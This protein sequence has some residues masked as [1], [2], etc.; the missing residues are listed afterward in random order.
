MKK[1]KYKKLNHEQQKEVERMRWD[2]NVSTGLLAEYII[3][4]TDWDIM[5]MVLKRIPASR[6]TLNEDH[7]SMAQEELDRID[8]ERKSY[9]KKNYPIVSEYFYR[10]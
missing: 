5:L 10:K 4:S 7:S 9:T 2:R 3:Y 1:H 6:K 8:L